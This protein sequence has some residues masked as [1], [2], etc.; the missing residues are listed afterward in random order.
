[1]K[2]ISIYLGVCLMFLVACSSPSKNSS[3]QTI[4]PYDLAILDGMKATTF[5]EED[6]K[7][8]KLQEKTLSDKDIALA[9]MDYSDDGDHLYGFTTREGDNPKFGGQ[10]LY[11]LNKKNLELEKLAPTSDS[12]FNGVYD[13]EYYY[14][15]AQGMGSVLLYKYDK[16]FNLVLERELSK[17][18]GVYPFGENLIASDGKLYLLVEASHEEPNAMEW[19]LEVWILSTDFELEERIDIDYDKA[20]NKQNVDDVVKVGNKLY[21]VETERGGGEAGSHGGKKV[22]V[23]DLDTKEL[24]TIS[25]EEEY[26]SFMLPDEE[27][28]LILI[29]H[30]NWEKEGL[31]YT[32]LNVETEKQEILDLSEEVEPSQ[33]AMTGW[34]FSTRQGDDYYFVTETKLIK[35]HYPSKKKTTY[36]LSEFGIKEADFVILNK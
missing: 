12:I 36:D 26:P 2:R 18:T 20:Y 29:S 8:I 11:L 23:Y 25:L 5:R 9:N 24:S 6:G 22:I 10:Y 13:G 32:F 17:E 30:D 1:M 34:D 21:I 27:K 7:L 19:G 33:R 16:D 35:Y 15:T 14:T 4:D 31:V 3:S 28:K